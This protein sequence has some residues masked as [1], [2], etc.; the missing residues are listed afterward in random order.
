[1]SAYV[2]DDD[3]DALSDRRIDIDASDLHLPVGMFPTTVQLRGFTY[4]QE[5]A[6][7]SPDGELVAVYYTAMSS[8]GQILLVVWND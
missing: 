1:M 7:Y 3:I 8:I 5:Q 2:I 4:R 6:R